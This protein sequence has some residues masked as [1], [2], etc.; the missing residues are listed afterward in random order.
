MTT[1]A[2]D[3]DWLPDHQLHVVPTLAHVERLIDHVTRIVHDYTDQG[4]LTLT[5]VVHDD[6]AHIK[7]TARISCSSTASPAPLSWIHRKGAGQ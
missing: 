4:P 5:E 7:V 1:S 6:R 2:A 3:Y